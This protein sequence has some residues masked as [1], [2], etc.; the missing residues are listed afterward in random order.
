MKEVQ[1]TQ[2]YVALVDDEDF[3]RVNAYKWYAQVSHKTVYA[4]RSTPRVNGKQGNQS[5]HRFLLN[6]PSGHDPEVDHK[7][8]NGLNCQRYNL[9]T[10]TR[11]QNCCNRNDKVKHKGISWSE[12]RNKWKAHIQVNR[13]EV[14]LGYFSSQEAAAAAYDVAA[15]KYYKEFALTNAM[16]A[17]QESS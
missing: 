3:E 12:R 5:M 1:L 16:L 8:R 14:H 7:D 13:K 15:L 11:Q 6:L 17:Q 4:H 9:R 10:A 2:G